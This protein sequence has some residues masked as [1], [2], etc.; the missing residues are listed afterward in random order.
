M[1]LEAKKQVVCKYL[2]PVGDA[3]YHRERKGMMTAKLN[4]TLGSTGGKQKACFLL[5]IIQIFETE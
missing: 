1:I 2:F 4:K 5:K 3:L